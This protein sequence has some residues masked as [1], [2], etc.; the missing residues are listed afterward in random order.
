MTW[1]EIRGDKHKFIPSENLC[2]EA[3]RRLVDIAQDDADGLYELRLSG[4][5]RVWGHRIEDVCHLVWWDPDH[6]VCP[7]TLRNT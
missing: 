7:S 2:T 4:T 1:G 6:T 3:R 5:E